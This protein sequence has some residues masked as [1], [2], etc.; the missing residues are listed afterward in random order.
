M[1]SKPSPLTTRAKELS[2][3]IGPQAGERGV[4]T[5]SDSAS[6]LI[7]DPQERETALALLTSLD[8][9]WMDRKPLTYGKTDQQSKANLLTL[10]RMM[11]PGCS[12]QVGDRG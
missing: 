12:S 11:L 10:Q 4:S 7:I 5:R 1:P 6:P 8:R 9:L 3:R 2:A